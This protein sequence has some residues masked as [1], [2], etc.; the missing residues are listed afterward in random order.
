MPRWYERA[1]C[2]GADPAIFLGQNGMNT[3]YRYK[4]AKAICD[5]C[6]VIQECLADAM[7]ISELPA[8]QDNHRQGYGRVFAMFQA[9]YTPK[10]LTDMY[11]EQESRKAA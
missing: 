8:W 7:S 2:L 3:R 5:S 4:K 11:Y 6:P 10:E 9:G 1:A